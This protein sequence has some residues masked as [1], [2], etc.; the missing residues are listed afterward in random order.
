MPPHPAAFAIPGDMHQK[1]GGYI[2]EKSLLLALRA[3]GRDVAHIQLPATFPDPGAADMAQTVATLAALP[4]DQPLILDGLVYG[5]IDTAGLATVCAPLIAMI[6]H[7]LGLET[8]LP[9][10]RANALLAREAAN[11]AL[12]AH[13]VVPSPHTKRIL[14]ADF[15]VNAD[16]ISIALPGF[17]PAD[18][19][20]APT[21]PPLILSVGL[22]AARKGHDVLIAALAAVADLP[23]QAQIVGSVHDAGVARDLSAQIMRLS[24]QDR[25]TLRGRISDD[26]LTGLYQQA[27]LFALATRYEGYGIVFGEAL[28]H[29]LPIVTCAAGAVP[30]TVPQ[31]AGILVP[32]DDATALATAMRRVL[33]DEGLRAAMAQ[34]ST[35]AGQALPRWADTAAIMGTVIDRLALT[36]PLG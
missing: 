35:L 10:A 1:T 6:H 25:I 9:A 7:P 33:T 27:S 28:L 32:V 29:G 3:A 16:R 13:V 23:W 36:G 34:A 19:V 5:A 12:A 2:Y 24:L 4:A 14:V 26:A 22:L 21:T 30:E 8:G 15:G 17:A 18:P 11:L 20:R 31:G